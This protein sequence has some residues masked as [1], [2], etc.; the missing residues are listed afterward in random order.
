MRHW[1]WG[2][3]RKRKIC[4]MHI[5]VLFSLPFASFTS[6][7][8]TQTH[9]LAVALIFFLGSIDKSPFV[10]KR[11]FVKSALWLQLFLS[12][13]GLMN[14]FLSWIA[15]V[16]HRMFSCTIYTRIP[17]PECHAAVLPCISIIILIMIRKSKALLV[18]MIEQIYCVFLA[19]PIQLFYK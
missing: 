13:V 10:W 7:L 15:L 12:S 2:K 6:V 17:V 19:A 11:C 18:K 5:R 16:I 8:W 1:G 14:F 9:F 3:K 4:E